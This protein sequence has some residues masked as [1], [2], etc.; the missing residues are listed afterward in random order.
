MRSLID[1][2]NNLAERLANKNLL[3]ESKSCKEIIQLF[4]KSAVEV[5]PY[6]SVNQP[7]EPLAW[8]DQECDHNFDADECPACG[9]SLTE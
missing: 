1:K 3:I 9:K 2:L 4:A 5:E 8:L 7:M 6:G